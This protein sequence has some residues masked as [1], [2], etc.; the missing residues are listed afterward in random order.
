MFLHTI[1]FHSTCFRDVIN[2]CRF[3]LKA[4][5]VLQ[6]SAKCAFAASL[7]MESEMLQWKCRGTLHKMSIKR[8][9]YRMK[10][11]FS[12]L[13]HITNDKKKGQ[14]VRLCIYLLIFSTP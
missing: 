12:D 8:K 9:Q 6:L 3:R 2:K 7:R 5:Y 11:F 4:N 13:L 14:R 1:R 10:V